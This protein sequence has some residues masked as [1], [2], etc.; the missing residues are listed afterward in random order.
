MTKTRELQ[1]GFAATTLYDH[2]ED[3]IA[4]YERMNYWRRFDS[5]PIQCLVRLSRDDHAK[6]R[7]VYDWAV[8]VPMLRQLGGWYREHDDTIITLSEQ[9]L[10]QVELAASRFG[11]N[12]AFALTMIEG[13]FVLERTAGHA[14]RELAR[15]GSG[16]TLDE[17]RARPSSREEETA[18]G[19]WLHKLYDDVYEK[20]SYD[21]R[22]YIEARNVA[23]M[24]S[25]T[26]L[27]SDAPPT[28]DEI[29]R[30]LS[31]RLHSRK[32][33]KDRREGVTIHEP[34]NDLTISDHNHTIEWVLG[35]NQKDIPF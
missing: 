29:R 11:Q 13:I 23:I 34:R 5:L 31:G 18:G 32:S 26:G 6:A 9:G 35:R 30:A 24:Y 10:K 27:A 12:P 21:L 33:A 25:I 16:M 19:H 3:F 4:H 20:V 1:P 7:R 2:F 14:E 17:L 28:E 15:H 22:N 8:R